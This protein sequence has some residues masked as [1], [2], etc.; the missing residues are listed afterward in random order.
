MREAHIDLDKR[1]TARITNMLKTATEDVKGKF[2]AMCSQVLTK[3]GIE[4][5]RPPFE[6]VIGLGGLA[7]K[8]S[9][10]ELEPGEF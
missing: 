2:D 8:L 1:E 10:W 6:I 4:D 9:Y 3:R 5:Y 7:V